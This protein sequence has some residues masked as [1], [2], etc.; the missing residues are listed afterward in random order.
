MNE[1]QN[2]KLLNRK[3]THALFREHG[4]QIGEEAI[5]AVEELVRDKI[6]SICNS[7]GGSIKRINVADVVALNNVKKRKVRLVKRGVL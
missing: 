2:S 4:K 5:K 1:T 7:M 6:T 3:L